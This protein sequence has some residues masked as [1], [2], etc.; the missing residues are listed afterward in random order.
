MTDSGF[1]LLAGVAA[2]DQSH[3]PFVE[4]LGGFLTPWD[5]TSANNH[6]VLS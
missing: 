6:R 1:L 2:F 5:C 4:P 3:H